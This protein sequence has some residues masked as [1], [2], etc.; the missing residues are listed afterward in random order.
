LLNAEP[1][2]NPSRQQLGTLPAFPNVRERA[3][4]SLPGICRNSVVISQY[5]ARDWRFERHKIDA[6]KSASGERRRL[7][8]SIIDALQNKA[9]YCKSP[10]T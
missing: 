6:R 7:A 10:W 2:K 9:N 3:S 1:N 4:E 5:L 8:A